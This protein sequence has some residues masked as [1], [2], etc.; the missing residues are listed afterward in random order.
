[1]VIYLQYIIH[2]FNS[3][4]SRYIACTTSARLSNAT[5]TCT[6]VLPSENNLMACGGIQN[7]VY[8]TNYVGCYN[9]FHQNTQ[10]ST[11]LTIVFWTNC[12]CST[13]LDIVCLC[14]HSRPYPP[15]RVQHWFPYFFSESFKKK[16]FVWAY[17]NLFPV[18]LNNVLRSQIYPSR[19]TWVGKK[20]STFVLVLVHQGEKLTIFVLFS[21]PYDNT[22]FHTASLPG[23][24]PHNI[25]HQVKFPVQEYYW[26]RHIDLKSLG[27]G[28]NTLE[29]L[30]VYTN[31]IIWWDINQ[32]PKLGVYV[33]TLLRF[34]IHKLLQI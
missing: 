28:D 20:G 30:D 15:G 23:G 32:L 8:W 7:T 19:L 31:I 33:T 21:S 27:E 17:G 18:L 12:S 26:V 24:S 16:C 6:G 29:V 5:T 14:T 22:D 3:K 11:S 25:K 10:H 13:E 2:P 9:S 34:W 1:L 4:Y